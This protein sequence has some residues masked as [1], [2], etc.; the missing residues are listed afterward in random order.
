MEQAETYNLIRRYQ[1]IDSTNRIA[2]ALGEEGAPHGSVILAD[3]QSDGRG[4]LSRK[5]VSPPGGLYLSV[6]LRPDLPMESV[7]LITLAAG[8]ACAV[9]IEKSSGVEVRL[10]WPNDLYCHG[11]KIGGILT[12]AGSY[13]QLSGS[14]PYVVVGIGLNINTNTADF[15]RELRNKVSSLLSLTG[16]EA[17]IDSLFDILVRKLL[18]EIV[19]LQKDPEHILSTWR[20]RDYL[21]GTMLTWEKPNGEQLHGIGSGLMS[22]GR[23]LLTTSGG[24]DYPVLA[25]DI[26]ISHINGQ[27][28]K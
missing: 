3:E 4:R 20:K 2:L 7:P 9:S 23:Y 28:I 19:L 5:F 16:K 11:R 6:V 27:N 10:K 21:M 18:A 12:Q 13:D 1:R 8:N 26:I 22:D 25:G 14:I 24:D 17:D 15:P